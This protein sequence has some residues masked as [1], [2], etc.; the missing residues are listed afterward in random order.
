[1]EAAWKKPST[2]ISIK[3]LEDQPGET[4]KEGHA[5]FTYKVK[6]KD[7]LLYDSESNAPVIKAKCRK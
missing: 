4:I 5:Y 7:S 3:S 1:M 6:I 2:V